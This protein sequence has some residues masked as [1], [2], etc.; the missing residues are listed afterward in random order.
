MLTN[1]AVLTEGFDAPLCDTV[2]MCRPTMSKVLYT[3]MVG[4]GTRPVVT[5]S[6]DMS[7]QGT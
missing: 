2:V 1:F 4:R 6:N 3:Q 7:L 5:L